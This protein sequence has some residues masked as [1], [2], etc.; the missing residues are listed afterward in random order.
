M[1]R[2]LLASWGLHVEV[3]TGPDGQP[4]RR[5]LQRDLDALGIR[6]DRD[7]I[8]VRLGQTRHLDPGIVAAVQDSVSRG[9]IPL[10]R[11]VSPDPALSTA[12]RQSLRGHQ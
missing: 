6:Q 11:F 1:S 8:E 12:Y 2:R 4:D 5:Q 3:E 9:R 7:P 10:P